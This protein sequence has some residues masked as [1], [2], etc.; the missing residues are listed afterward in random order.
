M[1]SEAV[2]LPWILPSLLAV[3]DDISTCVSDIVRQHFSQLHPVHMSLSSTGYDIDRLLYALNTEENWTL[4]ISSSGDQTPDF[5]VEDLFKHQNYIIFTAQQEEDVLEE[6]ID[7][8]EYIKMKPDWNARAKF[9]VVTSRNGSEELVQEIAEEMWKSYS[10]AHLLILIPTYQRIHMYTWRPFQSDKLCF[11]IS[12][13]L[14]AVW[15]QHIGTIYLTP[16]KLLS[17]ILPRNFHGCPL[18]VAAILGSTY[19]FIV[20]NSKEVEYHGVEVDYLRFIADV[21]NFTIQFYPPEV[22]NN[23]ELRKSAL[24]HLTE[25]VI[26]IAI[27]GFPWH[28]YLVHFADTSTSYIEDIFKIYVPCGKPFSRI[29]KVAHTFSMGVWIAVFSGLVIV[30]LTLWLL[31]QQF[32]ENSNPYKSVFSCL[33]ENWAVLLGV[34]VSQMPQNKLLRLLLI[35]FVWYSTAMTVVFQSFFVTNLVEP[36]YDSQVNNLEELH[37]KKYDLCL[38]PGI[39]E[40]LTRQIIPNY[41]EITLTRRHYNYT[42]CLIQYFTVS[43]ISMIG[44]T[45]STELRLLSILTPNKE[46]PEVCVLKENL[47]KL[48]YGQQFVKGSP[49]LVAFNRLIRTGLESGLFQNIM[50][51]FK[52]ELRF[53]H[54]NDSESLRL[55]NDEVVQFFVFSI[56]HLFIAFLALGTGLSFSF[57]VL[58]LE[59]LVIKIRNCRNLSISKEIRFLE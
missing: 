46:P 18:N 4:Q 7:Q 56:N 19:A 58:I 48:M 30:S 17:D 24:V 34:S 55:G 52:N 13:S 49:L 33:Y 22:G 53:M 54:S 42:K 51:N 20:N 40:L 26:D 6:L 10:I 9:L 43:D 8:L 14:V 41:Q 27:G 25:G 36:G 21:L 29:Y 23:A 11:E 47:Y 2:I 59:Y 16:N 50:N 35:H 12:V 3:P 32:Q 5:L 45:L 39:D 31:A 57:I 28:Q 38:P 44:I 1:V 37:L 15:K